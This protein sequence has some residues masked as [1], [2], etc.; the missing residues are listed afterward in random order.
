V[1]DR[2]G[3]H[4]RSA[5][6]ALVI[7]KMNLK[8]GGKQSIMHDTVWT[9]THGVQHQQSLV[10]QDG[11]ALAGQAKGLAVVCAE[12]G[13]SPPP[14][15]KWKKEQY[16]AA[17]AVQ[18]DVANVK[19]AAQVVCES[20]G[21]VW[22]ALPGCH[23]EFNEPEL[24]WALMKAYTK[25]HVKYNIAGLRQVMKEAR[26]LITPALCAKYFASVRVWQRAY[27]AGCNN[28]QAVL[29]KKLYRS[30]RRI[31]LKDAEKA[32]AVE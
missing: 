1:F 18:P 31:S 32:A 23:P 22:C 25:Q 17:L 13:I 10:F 11:H 2:S 5:D 19:C 20:L 21:D 28:V 3:V 8:S 29:V 16:I 24:M 26:E 9:D 14:G 7:S 27:A 6:D 12:R 4:L 15:V 30:H